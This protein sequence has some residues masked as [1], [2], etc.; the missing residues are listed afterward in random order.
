MRRTLPVLLA[1]LLAV[2]ALAQERPPLAPTRDVS[3]T[4]RAAGGPAGREIRMSWLVAEQKL[5]VDM[6]GGMGWSL[7]DQRAQ[8]MVMVMDQQRMVMELPMQ[9]GPGGLT[10]PTQPPDSARFT[11]GGSA[12]IAGLPCTVWQYQ[13]GNSRGEA[14]LTTDGVMLRS[15]GSHGGQ[16]GSVEAVAVAFGAQDPARFRVPAGYQPM[17]LPAGIMPGRPPAR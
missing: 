5:R 4:Y 16:S 8:K 9:G 14:C 15:S 13:D 10:I 2:P 3:V 17:Q 6:P 12:T 1:S 7:V 11:R